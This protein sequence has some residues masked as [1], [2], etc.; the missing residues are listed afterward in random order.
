MPKYHS[1]GV[2]FEWEDRRFSG[3]S[4]ARADIAGFV[5]IALRGPVGR[6]VR[7]ESWNQFTSAF[8]LHS[9]AGY[10]AWAVEGFFANGGKR[11]WVVRVAS[12]A[13][14]KAQWKFF[15]FDGKPALTLTAAS[16]GSW[17][18]ELSISVVPLGHG[19]FTLGLRLPDGSRETWRNVDIQK[20]Y[21][22]LTGND[23][24]GP[25]RV[26]LDDETLWPSPPLLEVAEVES[27]S[28][29]LRV[30]DSSMLVPL[31]LS[32]SAVIPAA[33]NAGSSRFSVQRLA[34][35]DAHPGMTAHPLQPGL[36]RF[37]T[38]PRFVGK[39]LNDGASG[40]HL[41]NVS[42][43]DFVPSFPMTSKCQPGADGLRDL[44]IE[45][46]TDALSELEKID[47][48][49]V[50][51][52]PDLME[53]PPSNFVAAK[54][55]ICCRTIAPA[56]PWPAP[57]PPPEM[58]PAFDLSKILSVQQAMVSQCVLLKDRIAI[59]DCPGKH[60]DREKATVWR[61]QFN[62]S[63][64]ACY[65]PWLLVPDLLQIEGMLRAIP[66][67]GHVAGIY[68]RVE[69]ATG[70]HKP[71]AN[72]VVEGVEDVSVMVDDT[73]QGL[74][75]DAQVNLI[76]PYRGRRV[77]VAGARTG[78]DD[79]AWMFVNVRRLFIAIERS[80][81][82]KLQWIAFEPARQDLWQQVDRVV[83][84]FLEDL[85]RRGLLDGASREEAYSVTC[86]ETTNPESERDKG[87]VL[88][89]IGVLPPW[90]AEFVVMR[91]GITE[92]AVEMFAPAEVEVG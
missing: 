4:L 19:V 89:E 52:I 24:R 29:H 77:R 33:M 91:I 11:C 43:S 2:Y 48:I 74:L 75:N 80:I 12:D 70:V 17:A 61:T 28:M 55:A 60:D 67:S 85:W 8:G 27:R 56:P 79:R 6:P 39:L 51:A 9:A 1:P 10:L 73:V 64:A 47:E 40:S 57:P 50:L 53:K 41:V 21:V 86:D 42:L 38:P 63:Y 84:S 15:S 30:E 5:G 82:V 26:T 90:P 18:K 22:D 54:R 36:L 81:R 46:F 25:T 58:P 83:R 34:K 76:N 71:P 13:A 49:A 72:E 66:P 65:Y 68:A 31:D 45:K 20:P 32:D 88:C 78:S 69:H 3:V 59:L 87:V 62:S 16:P 44:E 37:T 7:V 92:G 23:G 35:G 14:A